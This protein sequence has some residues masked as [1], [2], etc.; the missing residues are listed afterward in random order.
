MDSSMVQSKKVGGMV[1][2]YNRLQRI[3]KKTEAGKLQPLEIQE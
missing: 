1:E 3:L 2:K